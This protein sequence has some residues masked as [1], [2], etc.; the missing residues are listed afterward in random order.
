MVGT[1]TCSTEVSSEDHRRYFNVASAW[2]DGHI[3][4]DVRH[5]LKGATDALDL[6]QGATVLD[7]GSGTGVAVPLLAGS[8]GNEGRVFCLDPAERMLARAASRRDQ[9]CAV[10]YV[11][12]DAHSIPFPGEAFDEVFCFRCFSHFRDKMGAVGEIA[13]VLKPGGRFT[14][15]YPEGSELV[16]VHHAALGGVFAND[17]LPPKPLMARLLG[18]SGFG[19][20]DITDSRG[21]YRATA[22]KPC[23]IAAGD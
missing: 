15:L 17:K 7:L 6:A 16:N 13:R 2:W 1:V 14:V 18:E 5:F 12:G 21:R 11:W 8:V 19:S 9:Q 20:I 4:A 23:A 10:E 22:R 3:E